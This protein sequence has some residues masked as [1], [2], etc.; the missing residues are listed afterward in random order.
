MNSLNAITFAELRRRDLLAEADQA[1]LGRLAALARRCVEACC[2]SLS[3]RLLEVLPG[4]RP[5][6]VAC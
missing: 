4:R 5:T 1:R 3:R 2:P 6:R